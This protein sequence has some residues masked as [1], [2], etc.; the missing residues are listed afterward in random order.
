M[1][2]GE[3]ENLAKLLA[4]RRRHRLR[5]RLGRRRRQPPRRE[6]HRRSAAPRSRTSTCARAVV[7]FFQADENPATQQYLDLF[8]E[9]LP[10]GKAEA[11]PRLPG[12]S[13]RG[14]SSPPRPRSAA[15]TSP[16]SACTTTPRRS[17]SG[18]VAACTPPTNPSA[19]AGARVRASIVEA[20]PDGF[21]GARG[22]RGH[23]RALPLRR[24]QRR[25]SSRATTAR[26]SRSRAS[27]RAIDDLE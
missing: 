15:P 6:A 7:P 1:Y 24:R 11:L 4:G 2:T 19:S 22:L 13:R 25:A 21:A 8:E 27:A 5:A 14:C 12:R 3:P 9:Y 18:P 23:R 10:D 26:A 16:A 20:T 17:R